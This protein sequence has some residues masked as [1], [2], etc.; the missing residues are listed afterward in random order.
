MFCERRPGRGPAGRWWKAALATPEA[1]P[2]NARPTIVRAAKDANC[3]RCLIL[4]S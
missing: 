2:A 3:E 4:T 1:A